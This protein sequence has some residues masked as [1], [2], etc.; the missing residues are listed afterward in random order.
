MASLF[1]PDKVVP[2]LWTPSPV[3]ATPSLAP[4][5]SSGSGRARARAAS[6]SPPPAHP[7]GWAVYLQD[8]AQDSQGDGFQRSLWEIKGGSNPIPESGGNSIGFIWYENW[9]ESTAKKVPL[10]YCSRGN[11]DSI[12]TKNGSKIGMSWSSY[13][14]PLKK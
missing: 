8:K 3:P 13:I 9:N 4:S 10:Q 6:P 12:G 2:N 1:P 7:A 5:S 14:Y 11:L